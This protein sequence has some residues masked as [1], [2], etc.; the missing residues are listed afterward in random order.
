VKRMVFWSVVQCSSDRIRSFEGTL[1]LY[2]RSKSKL[3]KELSEAGDKF[4]SA[5]AGCLLGLHFNREDIS[6]IFLRNS[7]GPYFSRRQSVNGGLLRITGLLT[8]SNVRIYTRK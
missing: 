7:Q 2:S 1:P 5:F 3:N 8:L 4:G 6:D